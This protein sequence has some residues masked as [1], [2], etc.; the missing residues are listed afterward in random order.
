MNEASVQ[1]HVNTLRVSTTDWTCRW[2]QTKRSLTL[3]DSPRRD[4]IR[5]FRSL[6]Q[7]YPPVARSR[8]TSLNVHTLKLTS[9]AYS[10]SR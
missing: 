5:H 8:S 10:I 2:L 3:R 1:R 6:V 9:L 7:I 4:E